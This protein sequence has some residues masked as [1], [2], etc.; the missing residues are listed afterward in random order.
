[1]RISPQMPAIPWPEDMAPRLLVVVDTE[2]EFDWNEPFSRQATGVRAMR[3]Q[4]TAQRLFE[5]YGICPTYVIDFPV[6][7]QPDGFTPLAE[8]H[9][10]GRCRIGAHLHPWVNPPFDEE[11]TPENS[12][13]GN[14]APA[15]EREKLR[16]LVGAI[17]DNLGLTPTI[18]KAGRYGL[19]PHTPE[20]LKDLGF[21]VDMSIVPG[22]DFGADGGPDFTAYPE[23]PCWLGGDRRVLEIPVTSGFAGV[24]AS[25]GPGL[26]RRLASPTGLALHLPGVFA[27][28]GVIE[29]IRLTPEGTT[30]DELRRLTEAL[31][32]SGH[33]LFSFCYH[34]PSLEPGNTPYV[35]SEV[36]LRAFLDRFTRYF[37]YF[38]DHC[39]GVATT[40]DEVVA[41]ARDCSGP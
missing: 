14:L 40:P 21:E 10:D 11:V 36:E 23:R 19:G 35:C 26:Y 12:Y 4:G 25:R 3:A 9:A 30:F 5:P 34:S 2:E 6:A 13:P 31:L 20:T 16:R 24:L 33:K 37:E 27:R 28:T 7:S 17:E 15:L 38:L 29:R 18:Y 1:M 22:W 41:L 8:F 39:D 32:R